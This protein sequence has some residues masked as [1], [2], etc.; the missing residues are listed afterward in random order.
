MRSFDLNGI[1][2]KKSAFCFNNGLDS[3]DLFKP[4]LIIKVGLEGDW[5]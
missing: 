3:I 2:L 4:A 1:L 5:D